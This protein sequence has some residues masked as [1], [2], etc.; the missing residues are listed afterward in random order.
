MSKK[1]SDSLIEQL[2]HS[3]ESQELLNTELRK[4]AQIEVLLS[5]IIATS[6]GDTVFVTMYPATCPGKG[7]KRDVLLDSNG[8][9]A[10]MFKSKKCPYF[11]GAEFQLSNYT[12]AIDC[13]VE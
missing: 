12:K 6:E 11:K 10:C 7:R 1:V 4:I 3:K 5:S 9:A 2:I 13:T 8:E